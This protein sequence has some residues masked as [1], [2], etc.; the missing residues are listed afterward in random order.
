MQ[1]DQDLLN[2]YEGKDDSLL[3]RSITVARRG[4][5][6]TSRNQNDSSQSGDMRIPHQIK[7]SRRSQQRVKLWALASGIGEVSSSWIA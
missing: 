1:V 7:I 5:I 3:D 2:H 4:V 6:T